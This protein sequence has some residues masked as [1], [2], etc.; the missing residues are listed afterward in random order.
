MIP[1]GNAELSWWMIIGVLFGGTGIILVG[2]AMY[3]L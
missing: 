2:L 3:Y 1:V